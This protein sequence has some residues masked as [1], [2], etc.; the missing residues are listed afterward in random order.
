MQRRRLAAAVL[1]ALAVGAYAQDFGHDYDHE[2]FIVRGTAAYT[3]LGCRDGNDIPR[4]FSDF[5][6]RVTRAAAG[7][8]ALR[9]CVL[10][11]ENDVV[12]LEA[13]TDSTVALNGQQM[14]GY[15]ISTG[16]PVVDRVWFPKL[17]IK[18][19]KLTTRPTPP[20]PNPA[21]VV[22]PDLTGDFPVGRWAVYKAPSEWV[23]PGRYDPDRNANQGWTFD[24]YV[25]N[26][27]LSPNNRGRLLTVSGPDAR[28][29]GGFK[30]PA[31]GNAV[32]S[33]TA[34]LAW[35]LQDG[36]LRIQ[37]MSEKTYYIRG[38][39]DSAI[40]ANTAPPNRLGDWYVALRIGIP[41]E[42]RVW[43]FYVC[44]SQNKGKPL[45]EVKQCD[46]SFMADLAALRAG[47][48]HDG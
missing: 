3:F 6:G 38:A 19:I 28:P 26:W 13:P 9:G 15:V 47:D 37:T 36:A 39:T 18:N 7:A 34:D 14:E 4:V 31:G 43:D 17:F 10:V 2:R 11:A 29:D 20:K 25:A 45:F 16:S 42:W 41:L 12:Y 23:Y 48:A 24:P 40:V 8:L 33:P 22:V 27:E 35:R 46:A 5:G 32:W 44:V 30:F 21:P 1:G